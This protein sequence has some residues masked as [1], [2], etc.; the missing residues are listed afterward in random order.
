MK[1][2]RRSPISPPR[3]RP[4]QRSRRMTAIA[5]GDGR[6]P[7]AHRNGRPRVEVPAR[8]TRGAERPPT[9]SRSALV[10]D[11]TRI[12]CG[13]RQRELR[14]AGWSDNPSETS[15]MCQRPRGRGFGVRGRQIQ[16]AEDAAHV[17][18][19]GFGTDDESPAMRR[20]RPPSA[21]RS[22]TSRSRAVSGSSGSTERGAS[23]NSRM[24]SG[25]TTV[26]PACTRSPGRHR[27]SF[28]SGPVQRAA[29]SSCSPHG[30]LDK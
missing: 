23:S 16:L 2:T 8:P 27:S 28:D 4:G 17:G 1:R 10:R 26:S 22:R 20:S 11:L 24:R 18:L 21:I 13:H 12:R 9:V 6:R 19:D 25:S 7:R 15:A 29:A 30:A 14:R 5:G 3:A